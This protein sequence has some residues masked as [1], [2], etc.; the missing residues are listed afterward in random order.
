EHRLDHFSYEDWSST[1][2]RM[3]LYSSR[4]AADALASG[5]SASTGRLAFAPG[6]RFWKQYLLQ[7][8]FRDGVHGLIL[9]G[10]SASQLFLKLAKMRLGEVPAPPASGGSPEV[11]IVQ[12]P[13]PR[14]MTTSNGGGEEE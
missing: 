12:G 1:F 2:G 10:L 11:E 4:G 8:G 9:C 6:L 14:A 5:K 3:L 7:G 13:S